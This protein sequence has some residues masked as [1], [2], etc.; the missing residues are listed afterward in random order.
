MNSYFSSDWHLFHKKVLE[1]DK[2]PFNTIEEHNETIIANYNAIVKPEDNF[3]Y[4]GDFFMSKDK[5]SEGFLERMMG[6]KFFIKGNHDHKDLI[7]LYQK[8]GT[9]L[10]EQKRIVIDGLDIVLNHFPMRTWNR[11]H[12][13][14]FHLYGHHHGWIENQPW[15]RSM[16]VAINYWDYKPVSFETVNRILSKRE[17]GYISGDHHLER[18]E[19]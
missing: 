18:T 16:D 4:L 6:N 5:R 12:K 2:R 7:K 13:G 10:G 15:G 3:Y 19:S 9:Y 17:I 8:H 11:S 14:S 1:F